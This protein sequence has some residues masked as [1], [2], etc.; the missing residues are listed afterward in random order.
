MILQLL[1]QIFSSILQLIFGFFPTVTT[2]PLGIDSALSTAFGWLHSF[3]EYV[4]PAQVI[5]EVVIY[6]LSFRVLLIVL[7]FFIGNRA[8]HHD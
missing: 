3:L 6:Y 1:I 4:W 8:P 2:L 5:Y 7:K